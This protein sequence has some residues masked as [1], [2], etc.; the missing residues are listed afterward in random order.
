M[1]V[2]VFFMTPVSLFGAI[3]SSLTERAPQIQKSP[4]NIR[5]TVSPVGR[6][7]LGGAT[8]AIV[9][10]AANSVAAPW[11]TDPQ[12]RLVSSGAFASVT[13]INA[14]SVTPLLSELNLYDAVLV[15]SNQSFDD[16]VALGDN[17]ADYVDGGG[18]VVVAAFSNSSTSTGRILTGRW[19]SGDYGVI[20]DSSGTTTGS[21]TIGTIDDP[22]HPIMAGVS[23]FAGGTSSFRPTITSLPPS[24]LRIAAWDDGSTLI[25]IRS[26]RAGR[27]ID[28][29]FYPPSDAVQGDFWDST[30]DGGDILLN[31]MVFAVSG[32]ALVAPIA[33]SGH[34][35]QAGKN[36]YISF[37][38]HAATAGIM[39]GYQ[40][41]HVDSGAAW[42]ISTPRTTPV[43]V[44][45]ENLTFLVSDTT[46]P[47]FDFGALSVVHVGG[48][49]IAPGE[50]Y[51]IHATDGTNFSAPLVVSTSDVPTNSRFWADVVGAFSVAGSGS[52]TPPTPPNS[53]EPPNGAMNGF[54]VTAV[55]RGTDAADATRPHLTW[56]DI[57]G[58]PASIT[59]RATNGNDVLRAVNA[60]AT[61][62]G[63]EFYATDHPDVGGAGC[64]ICDVAT[65]GP[66]ATP[67]LESALLP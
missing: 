17:L 52:T 40:V 8:V 16:P 9:A 10:S 48:C 64:P 1:S 11:F 57:D 12:N 39:L 7:Q 38:P 24:A 41:T 33:A 53:W 60:F 27:R 26:D 58:G 34:P 46:L 36:K 18:N 5:S 42:Y 28:L 29:G 59:N 66:C 35:H 14:G 30:T 37:S 67:P 61:G 44:A 23:T 4:D 43:A 19:Q 13:V 21:A 6:T 51:E 22:G 54:D 55:L 47:T 25:A 31:A 56:T 62:T 63:R 32:S 49:L 45:S 20:P 2:L 65:S 3:N 15:W 50:T